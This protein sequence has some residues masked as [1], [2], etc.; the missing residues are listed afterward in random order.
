MKKELLL[1]VD[2]SNG[3]LIVLVLCGWLLDKTIICTVLWESCG[4]ESLFVRL[5]GQAFI[6]L[7]LVSIYLLLPS[8]PKLLLLFLLNL[9]TSIY[10]LLVSIYLLLPSH[11]KLLLLH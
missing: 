3:L 2:L 6:L 8:H 5:S 11:P 1:E 7:L 10:L 4:T 9:L